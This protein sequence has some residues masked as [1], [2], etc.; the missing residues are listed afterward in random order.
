MKEFINTQL[1]LLSP[2]E[3]GRSTPL[4]ACAY[5]ESYRPHI[6]LGDPNQRKAIVVERD[7]VRNWIEEEYLGVAFFDGPKG[8]PLPTGE[9]MIVTM[10]LCYAPSPVYDK[11]QADATFTLRE[12][13]RV[14]GF[15]KIIRR[16]KE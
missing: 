7:G 8:D 10:T 2:N 16:W 4:F 5:G 6:V 11:V 12:G 14:I 3:G 15:G 9:D 1:T 13:G